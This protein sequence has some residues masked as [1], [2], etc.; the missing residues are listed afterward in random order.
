M[1]KSITFNELKM[2]VT[3]RSLKNILPALNTFEGQL[4]W[5]GRY[6]VY[7]NQYDRNRAFEAIMEFRF[8]FQTPSLGPR[9]KIPFVTEVDMMI[10]WIEC[11]NK[12]L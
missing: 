12:Y 5:L 4:F 8:G 3:E 2:I 6:K 9:G 1:A 7:L 11:V 10:A